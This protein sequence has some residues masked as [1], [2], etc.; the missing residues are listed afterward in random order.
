MIHIDIIEPV[1]QKELLNI[2]FRLTNSLAIVGQSGSG[3]SLIIKSILGLLPLKLSSNIN[4]NDEA[5]YT[6]DEIGFVPQNPFTALSP[7]T[8][9][10]EQFF[11]D[12]DKINKALR[13]V[14][15]DI[16]FKHKFPSQLSGGQL[17]RVIIAI[18]LI[19]R[20]KL[21]LLDEPTT[22][23]DTKT[24]HEIIDLLNDIKDEYDFKL[25]F[26]THEINLV[27]KL[28]E[29]ILVIKDGEMIENG[30]AKDVLSAPKSD[31]TQKLIEYSFAN[32][33]FRE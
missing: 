32:K 29:D 33:R 22:A 30:K 7:L 31:Y 14:G 20:P 5:S 13:S 4:Y 15:L 3:K 1:A 26:V 27:S 17:Q 9:I 18:S 25:L 11:C 6:L 23:L 8:T 2:D 24:K 10:K 28:C 16:E 21:L 12:E 19:K